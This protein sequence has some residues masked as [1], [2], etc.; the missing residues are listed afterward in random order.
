MIKTAFLLAEDQGNFGH[1]KAEN[2]PIEDMVNNIIF[3][4]N[5]YRISF[6]QNYNT[7]LF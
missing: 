6:Q 5:I 7:I 3:V 4:N 1:E 2:H